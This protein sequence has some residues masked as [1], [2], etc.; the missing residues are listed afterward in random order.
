VVVIGVVVMAVLVVVELV[1]GE[2]VMEAE[3][4]MAPAPQVDELVLH[5]SGR[6]RD[7]FPM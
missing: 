4:V 6:F 7:E 5:D 2:V 3:V 1:G